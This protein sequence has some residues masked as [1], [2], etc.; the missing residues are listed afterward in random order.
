MKFY[1]ETTISLNP[2]RYD[3]MCLCNIAKNCLQKSWDYRDEEAFVSL[4]HIALNTRKELLDWYYYER[5]SLLNVNYSQKRPLMV[6]VYQQPSAI[7]VPHNYQIHTKM[8]NIYINPV[9]KGIPISPIAFNDVFLHGDI[10][11]MTQTKGDDP[12]DRYNMI[13]KY[14][15]TIIL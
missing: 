4:N 13:A 10:I 6:Y 15:K 8:F 14:K 5:P 7:Y 12:N 2:D 3:F 1:N 11:T 9:G